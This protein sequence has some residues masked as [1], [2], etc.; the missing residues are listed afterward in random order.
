MLFLFL[1]FHLDAAVVQVSKPVRN[2]RHLVSTGERARTLCPG[3]KT[4]P[5]INHYLI[6]CRHEAKLIWEMAE[7]G[8]DHVDVKAYK[9]LAMEAM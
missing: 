5:Q 8:R 4:Q 1:F 6:V 7:A 3:I 9:G 2:S